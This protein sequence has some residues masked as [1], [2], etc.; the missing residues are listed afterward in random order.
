MKAKT[1][2]KKAVK[3]AYKEREKYK[4][5]IQNKGEEVVEYLRKNN[6]KVLSDKGGAK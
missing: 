6:K 3:E 4:Q 2:A 1:E 5:D